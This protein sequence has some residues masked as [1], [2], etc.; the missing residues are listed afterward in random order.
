LARDLVQLVGEAGEGG[1]V[2]RHVRLCGERSGQVGLLLAEGLEA[3][4]VAANAFLTNAA[5][6]AGLERVEVA[7][8]L[9]FESGDL[10]AREGELI[11]DPG[12]LLGRLHRRVGE[13]SL[14]QPVSRYRSAS[15][16]RTAVS[17]R[18][19]GSRSPLH[20]LGPYLYRV[21]QA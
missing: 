13:R 19:F 5:E 9:P 18:S 21:E 15:C 10:G 4:T 12:A 7:L 1:R 16:A 2:R 3:L 8:E 17:S 11:F 6:L 14:E 20:L